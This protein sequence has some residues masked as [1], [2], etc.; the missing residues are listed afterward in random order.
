VNSPNLRLAFDS[1]S[2]SLGLDRS[3]RGMDARSLKAAVLVLGMHRSGTSSVAGALMALGGS[4]PLHLMPPQE[5]NERGFWESAVLTALNDEILAAGGSAWPDWRAFDPERID[6]AAAGDLHARAISAL[7]NEFVDAGLPIVKDPRM[8]RLMRLW[9][10]VFEEAEWSVRALLPLRSPLEVVFSLN[11][12]DGVS[13]S[14]GC[15]MWLRHV[16]DAEAETRG[17]ARAV[18]DWQSFLDDRRGAL[19]RV[20]EQLRLTWPRWGETALAEID[21]FVSA[22]LRHHSAGGDDLRAHPAIC[23]LARE[24]YAAMIELVEDPGNGRVLRTLDDL[25]LRLEA[26]ALTFDC[27]MHELEEAIGV[28]NREISRANA[29]IAHVADRY[30]EMSRSSNRTGLCAFRKSFRKA[31]SNAPT[32]SFVNSNELE[33]IRNSVFFDA[34]HYLE[35]NPDVRAAGA[36]PALHY[37]LHGGLEGRAPGPFFST[38]AYLARYPD[39]AEAGLNALVHYETY[40]RLEKRNLLGEPILL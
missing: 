28:A 2:V 12:R 26:A 6:P 17:M 33:T 19:T 22:D 14:Y 30:A 31:R 32:P 37:L 25:R 5:D 3:S 24:T 18:L 40:G 29:I 34:K 13:L 23:D 9:A 36:D 1:S 38:V 10:P 27:P 16:L 35:T 8:C 39:V 7:A 11:H 4:A 20:A 15:L 21:E